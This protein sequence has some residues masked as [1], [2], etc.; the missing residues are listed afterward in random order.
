MGHKMNTENT[1]YRL[2]E[3]Q[4]EKAP[5]QIAIIDGNRSITYQDLNEKANQLAHYLR[6]KGVNPDTKVALCLERSIDLFIALLGI[7]KAGGAYIPLDASHPEERLL[8]ILEDNDSPILITTSTLQ[9]KFSSYPGYC[10]ALELEKQAIAMHAIT[11]PLPVALSQHLAYIIYTSGSTGKPK[12]VLI[13]HGSVVNYAHW[14]MDYS[15]TQPGQRIDFSANFIFDMAITSTIIPLMHGLTIVIASNDIKKTASTYLK[16]LADQ[17]VNV[18]KLTPSYLKLLLH[19]VNNNPSPLPHLQTIILGGENLTKV[20]C[21]DWLKVYPQHN[22]FNE[23]GPTEASVAVSHYKVSKE[24][25]ATLE[26]NIPIGKTGSNMACYILDENNQPVPDGVIGELHIGG[27][28]LARGYLNQAARTQEKF[29]TVPFHEGRLYKTGDLCLQRADGIL[30]YS[31]RIDSQIKIRGF[32]VETQEIEEWLRAHPLIENALVQVAS[33]ESPEK[34]LVAYYILKETAVLQGHFEIRDYLL[35]HLPEYMIPSMFIKLAYFPLTANGKIDRKALSNRHHDSDH[36]YTA[37]ASRL[38]KKLALI[39]SRELRIQS[40]GLLDNFFEL[41]G[42]SLA[43]ARI[44]S[45]INHVMGK[46]VSLGEFYQAATFADLA[47]LIKKAKKIPKKPLKLDKNLP[48]NSNT[49]PLGDFQF[50]LW[51]T[52]TFERKASKLNIVTRKRMHG[53]V[54]CEL[55]AQAFD[56]VFQKHEIFFYRIAKLR[57]MQIVQKPLPFKFKKED[58]TA[59]SEQECAFLLENSFHELMHHRAW[60]ANRPLLKARL[61]YLPGNMLELQ[62]CLPHIISDDISAEIIVSELSHCYGLLQKKKGQTLRPDKHFKEYVLIEHQE[63]KA[64]IEPH[65]NFWDDYLQDASLFSFPPERVIKDMQ[66]QYVPYS[67][68]L[69]MPQSQITHLQNYCAHHHLSFN[70]GLSAALLLAIRNCCPDDQKN[71]TLAINLVKSTRNHSRYDKSI[72]C[73]L[74][75]DPL[76]ANINQNATLLNISRQL[77]QSEIKTSAYQHCSNLFKLACISTFRQ[78]KKIGYYITAPLIYLGTLLVSREKVSSHVRQL[79]QR[80]ISFKRTNQFLINI[81]VHNSFIH[82]DSQ[83]REI[84]G[85]KQQNIPLSKY[86]LLNIDYV[87]D[88]CFF[89]ADNKRYMVISANLDPEFRKQIGMEMIRLVEESCMEPQPLS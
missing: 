73:F 48:E 6:E 29:I 75:I 31:G 84:F 49:L 76:K 82:K 46:Q 3:I 47:M 15:Q 63:T 34:K 43:A 8:F 74:R 37:P 4:V 77:Q 54:D 85:L 58:L 7:L 53:Q 14:F 26:M 57:P 70:Q 23:Y 80:L 40:I 87:F 11:N 10:L 44:I 30:E 89:S 45:D 50:L 68:Y 66:A 78:Q 9:K 25:I 72:G 55:L 69:E 35:T 60:H 13:E 18:I 61:F 24:N 65:I 36:P 62:L 19:E 42:D 38:E 41:G 1:V 39:W 81:N 2:F 71:Q 64:N 33:E 59:I 21:S 67:T 86:D 22:L 88:A 17:R 52:Q 56:A 32:R 51:M 16:H 28:C 79:Y 83:N 27:L 12:G 5:T 20:E